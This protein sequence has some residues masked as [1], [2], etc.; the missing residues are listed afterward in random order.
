[1]QHG[2][3]RRIVA[4]ESDDVFIVVQPTRRKLTQ[5]QNYGPKNAFIK[6]FTPFFSVA[7]LNVF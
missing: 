6:L 5:A 3:T 4:R 1:M 2:I 7:V